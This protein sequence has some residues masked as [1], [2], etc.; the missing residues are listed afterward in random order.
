M[1]NNLK[2][3]FSQFEK[4]IEK[5]IENEVIELN[6]KAI[7]KTFPK[8]IRSVDNKIKNMYEIAIDD[9]YKSYIPKFY[10]DRRGSLYDL[11][12]TKYD[13]GKQEYSYDFNPNKITYSHDSNKSYRDGEF[14]LYNT[15]F[16]AG[17]HG[18][19]FHDGDMYWRTPY[20]YYTYWGRPAESEERSPLEVFKSR[21]D[22]YQNGKM[23]KDFLRIYTESL[24]S[25]L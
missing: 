9:F 8:F 19:A 3:Q 20:P 25:L 24:Y 23:K 11:L 5:Y 18:G 4:N 13:A 6:E 15:V 12:E 1:N 10:Y 2:N 16:R 17:Y 14:G 22:K 21:L 7:E